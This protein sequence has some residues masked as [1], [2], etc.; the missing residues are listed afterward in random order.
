MTPK[1][2]TDTATKKRRSLHRDKISPLPDPCPVAKVP[3]SEAPDRR[4]WEQDDESNLG[5]DDE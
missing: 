1:H 5:P 4:P 3:M 2:P